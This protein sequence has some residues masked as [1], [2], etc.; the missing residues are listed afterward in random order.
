MAE[1]L[2]A[3]TP[4]D[5]EL[6]CVPVTK[7]ARILAA[8][9]DTDSIAACLYSILDESRQR[10][11]DADRRA[12]SCQGSKVPMGGELM[13]SNKNLAELTPEQR[14]QRGF[15]ESAC[16]MTFDQC[17]PEETINNWLRQ[18]D[19]HR[20]RPQAKMGAAWPRLEKHYTQLRDADRRAGAL[21]ELRVAMVAWDL[22]SDL[23]TGKYLVARIAK[24][25]A[26]GK[27]D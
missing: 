27:G 7:M 18:V 6:I 13:A 23:H 20:R 21:E 5:R 11:R 2:A 8:S 17:V 15:E 14:A 1:N 4:E 19:A 22:S 3:M 10:F 25:E 9:T 26:E 12:G 24:L 16:D